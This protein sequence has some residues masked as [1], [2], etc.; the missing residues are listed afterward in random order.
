MTAPLMDQRGNVHYHIGA[1]I[2]ITR[3]LEGGKGL[4]SFKQVLEQEQE[5]AIRDPENEFSDNSLSLKMLRELGGLLN[6]QEADIVRQRSNQLK[7]G[8]MNSSG[9]APA[10]PLPA[11]RRFVGMDELADENIW[12]SGKSGSG[13]RLPGVYQN[14]SPSESM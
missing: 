3:L 11:G 8:S 4:E 9:S 6:D 5:A 10:R 12:S 14:V 1:Q 2:D 7:K 13:G